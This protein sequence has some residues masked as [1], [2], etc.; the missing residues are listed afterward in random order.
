MRACNPQRFFKSAPAAS[1]FMVQGRAFASVPEKD[2]ATTA[3]EPKTDKASTTTKEPKTESKSSNSK[4]QSS[5]SKSNTKDKK[6]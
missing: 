6:H 4:E 2:K 1:R 3:K 5:N